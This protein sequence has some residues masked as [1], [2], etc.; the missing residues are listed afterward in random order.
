MI[1]PMSTTSFNRFGFW[2]L[3]SFRNEVEAVLADL[4]YFAPMELSP[5]DHFC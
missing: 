5:F 4:F 3:K 2:A 1:I